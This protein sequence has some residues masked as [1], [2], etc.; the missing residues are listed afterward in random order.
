MSFQVSAIFVALPTFVHDISLDLLSGHD[1]KEHCWGKRGEAEG[2]SEDHGPEKF[3]LLA[4]LGGVKCLSSDS[5][6]NL[7]DFDPKGDLGI[8]K[9]SLNENPSLFLESSV[10]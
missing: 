1:H 5:Q 6:C 2:D 7:P 8:I 3:N 9:Q 10:H 4:E